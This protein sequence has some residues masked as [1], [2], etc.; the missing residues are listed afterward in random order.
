MRCLVNLSVFVIAIVLAP[1]S[2]LWARN[3]SAGES[4]LKFAVILTRH[5]IR[6]PIWPPQLLNSYSSDPWPNWGVPPGNLTPQGSK[7]MKLF[8]SYYRLYFSAAGLLHAAGC[9]DAGH[10]DIRADAEQRT[11]DTGRSLASGMMPGCNVE[12]QTIG[13]GKDPLFSP[14]AAGIGKPDRALA[15]ASISGRIGANPTAL[16]AIHRHAFDSLREVLFGCAPDASCP[17]ENKAGKQ[18]LLTQSSVVQAGQGDHAADLQGPLRTGSTLAEDFLLEYV[19]GMNGKDLGWGRLDPAKLLEM[20]RLHA[21]YADLARQ[22]PY[23]ARVQASNLLSHILR[24]MEQALSK[25]P[26]KGSVGKPGDRVLILVG[27]DTNISNIAGM[28]GISWLLDGYQRDDTP[29]GGALVS[30]IWQQS[31]GEFAVSTYFVAQSLEQMRKALP[32]TL[33]LPPLTSPIFVPGC[34]TADNKMTCTWK[35]FQRTV[36]NAVDPAFVKP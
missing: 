17:A 26:I 22:T 25:S 18:I 28:L 10:I 34:S 35:A 32:L 33:D 30:E 7:L 16:V 4:K 36:E 23:V 1:C 12:V 31:S 11:R 21:A 8:G 2:P 15:A 24:S 13:E 20:M 19:N 3:V 14:R 27:H 5:G 9:E 29:P 6:S